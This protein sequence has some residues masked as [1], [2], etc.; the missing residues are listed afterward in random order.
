M[1]A[2]LFVSA[3]KYEDVF[4]ASPV[5]ATTDIRDGW[6]ATNS[7]IEPTINEINIDEIAA[8]E[9]SIFIRQMPTRIIPVFVAD[10]ADNIE[11]IKSVN[12]MKGRDTRLKSNQDRPESSIIKKRNAQKQ[13]V[14]TRKN[15]R[16]RVRIPFRQGRQKGYLAPPVSPDTSYGSP[17]ANLPS[18]DPSSVSSPGSN[19]DTRSGKHKETRP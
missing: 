6:Q 18:Y 17:L 5:E 13:F 9:P 15:K 19:L 3:F 4:N 11:D 7:F 2:Q 1:E 8:R 12:E 10:L 14:R 16:V